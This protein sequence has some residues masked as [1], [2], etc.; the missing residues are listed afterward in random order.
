MPKDLVTLTDKTLKELLL[1][2]E[3]NVDEDR[4]SQRMGYTYL[5]GVILAAN[6]MNDAYLVVEGPDCV[7]MKSQY[8][9]GSHD[10]MSTLTS[11]SGYHRIV[12]T[13]VHPSMM[14]ESRE[15][16]L[17]SIL[18]E[19][20][21]NEAVGGVLVTAM[22]MAAV[23]GVDYGRLCR[24]TAQKTSKTVIPVP[25]LSLRGDWLDG[26]SESL[27]ALAR[28][29]ELAPLPKRRRKKRP[30][31]A[32]VGYLF[33]RN[34]EDHSANLREIEEIFDALDL[35]LVS[36]WLSGQRFDELGRVAE[37][38]LIIALPYGAAAARIISRRINAEILELPVPFGPETIKR[39]VR[40]LAGR[41]NRAEAGESY[42][43]SRISFVAR[44]L[45][46]LVP[47]VFQNI[48]VGYI[49]D[50][51]LLPGFL[52]IARILGAVPAFAVI[53]NQEHHLQRAMADLEDLPVLVDPRKGSFTRFV[54]KESIE[55]GLDLLLTN[56]AGMSLPLLHTA[57]VEL[58]FPSIHT[59]SL[60]PRPF[61]GFGGFL[62]LA[63]TLATSIRLKEVE[64]DRLSSLVKGMGKLGE[65]ED[66][67]F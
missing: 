49:G 14:V 38:D 25:G 10:W 50:P 61:L 48:R 16:P 43:D 55:A 29:V 22:P 15:S 28:Q 19:V 8:I 27:K 24:E 21:G 40:T 45:E 9:Q 62:A 26:Y 17:S 33:D 35:E 44:R 53:T 65:G 46:W 30:K 51:F 3:R 12:N 39:W 54:L 59:H 58:G 18:M 34:E 7:Y 67:L 56:N 42:I 66:T 52:E 2:L 63:D 37:A 57:F 41:W 23:T 47:F 13:A 6:A 60:Y 36:V 11:V 4:Y 5:M 32:V 1:L 64:T 20:A 31:V